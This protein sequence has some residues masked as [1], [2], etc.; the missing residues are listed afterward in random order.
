MSICRT[1]LRRR[2]CHLPDELQEV[3]WKTYHTSFILHELKTH[4]KVTVQQ[5]YEHKFDEGK[6]LLKYYLEAINEFSRQYHEAYMISLDFLEDRIL[7]GDTSSRTFDLLQYFKEHSSRPFHLRMVLEE[8]H[9]TTL[10]NICSTLEFV[11]LV[12]NNVLP[13]AQHIN[14][15]I[16][17]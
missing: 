14:D 5:M 6:S 2:I 17:D 4:P 7:D 10:S 15:Q 8:K 12:C 16:D 1:I 11:R 13:Y 9:M 3:V